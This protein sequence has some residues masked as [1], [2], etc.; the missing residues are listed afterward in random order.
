M[1]M[2]KCFSVTLTAVLVSS[3]A[4]VA[5]TTVSAAADFVASEHTFGII[6]GFNNWTEDIAAM[7]YVDG[8]GIYEG[9]YV[10]TGKETETFEFKVRA[11][12]QWTTSWGVYEFSNDA[13]Y[14]QDRTRNSQTNF[15]VTLSTNQKLIVRL[16]TTKV[17]DEAVATPGSYVNNEAFD[18]EVDGFEFWPVTFEV[19]SIENASTIDKQTMLLGDMVTIKCSATGGTD[20]KQYKV[21]Y[22]EPNSTTWKTLS[23]YSDKEK[24]T[25]IPKMVGQYAIRVRVKDSKENTDVKDLVLI[26]TKGSLTNISALSTQEILIDDALT[27]NCSAMGGEGEWQFTVL[28]QEPNS[29]TWK[30]LSQYSDKEEVTFT[31]TMVGQYTLRV[32]V[33]DAEENTD[34]KDLVL[35]VTKEPLTNTSTLSQQKIL[36]SG[37]GVTIH[38]SAEGGRRERQYM[39]LYQ[40]PNSTEWQTLSDY[41]TKSKVTFAPIITGQYTIR[42]RVKD[43]DGTTNDKDLTLTVS[44]GTL[45]NTSAI[46]Q[47]AVWAGDAVTISCSATGGNG[48]KQ[49][50]LYYQEPDSSA[51]KTASAYSFQ[52]KVTFT[53]TLNGK[54]TLRIRAKDADGK[55][56]AKD[57]TLHS[58][59]TEQDDRQQYFYYDNSKTNWA[60]VYVYWIS[61]DGYYPVKDADGNLYGCKLKDNSDYYY[62]QYEFFQVK[63]EQIPNTSI[64]QAK[65]PYGTDGYIRFGNGGSKYQWVSYEAIEGVDSYG[66]IFIDLYGAIDGK[67]CT[68]AANE[69]WKT[70]TGTYVSRLPLSNRSTL[71]Q[72]TVDAGQSLTIQCSAIGGS[73][74]QK[75]YVVLYQKKG[76][77]AWKT[78]SAYSDKTE[79]TFKPT[80]KG[81]YTIRVRAKDITGKTVA[82]DLTL[83]VTA[84]SLNNTSSVRADSAFEDSGKIIISLGDPLTIDCKAEGGTGD[85]QFTVLYQKEG[86]TNWKTL[87]S[88]STNPQVTFKPTAEG[89]Y[90]IRVRAK[91]TTGKTAVKNFTVRVIKPLTNNS[92]LG[93]ASIKLGDSV[94]IICSAQNGMGSYQYAVYYKKAS[95]TTWTKLRGY[96]SGYVLSLTPKAAVNYDIRV[97]AKDAGGNVSSKVLPLTVTK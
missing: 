5:A 97:D 90:T 73:T 55:T 10:Y 34:V 47:Q 8:D 32:C 18:F 58:I 43:A 16:D 21:L 89:T 82:K 62:D 36:T 72:D 57:F 6:G 39:V 71:S 96:N 23:A 75:Q 9:A 56:A 65:V 27:V 54:Y 41:S 37:N 63:M 13:E 20:K 86:Q 87:S 91:D 31:P 50:R 52:N 24:V 51:W 93:T 85:K 81:T 1:K 74:G 45:K 59:G 46:S 40:E 25:F 70:Y 66:N 95:S 77:T 3:V 88:Y 29:T 26:V 38:Y 67:I 2:K 79:V 80:E 83:T 7:T 11:D 22:Q 28:Y 44:A 12:G 78:L 48:E 14:P 61:D 35:T 17:A 60:N 92:M 94:T 49:F 19:V 4:A 68:D 33:K 30:T 76:Q 15:K 53:P 69:T 84:P 42:V 64:W